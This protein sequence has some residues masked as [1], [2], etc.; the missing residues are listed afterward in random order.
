MIV[1][2]KQFMDPNHL[3]DLAKAFKDMCKG[4]VSG[5]T[6]I[7]IT[8]EGYVY[9]LEAATS[10]S[11]HI[12]KKSDSYAI[13][14]KLSKDTDI[15]IENLDHRNACIILVKYL[16]IVFCSL[17]DLLISNHFEYCKWLNA[18]NSQLLAL[19]VVNS[20]NTDTVEITEVINKLPRYIHDRVNKVKKAI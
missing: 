15:E 10:L 5:K 3:T 4:H 6:D 12:T 14:F 16:I 13:K 18:M 1:S 11:I 8:N 19:I 2:E 9:Y 7:E 20:K 17:A